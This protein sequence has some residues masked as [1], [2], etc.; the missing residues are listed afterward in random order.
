VALAAL[1]LGSKAFPV[2]EDVIREGLRTVFWPGRFEI[3]RENPTVLLDGAHNG[4]G[5]AALAE[6]LERYRQGRSIKLLF[7]SMED[8]DWRLMLTTLTRLADEVVLTRVAME[9]SAD[10]KLLA[11]HVPEAICH[12]VIEDARQ[13]LSFLLD[14]AA[15]D[16]LIVVAGSLY[17]LG[18]VRPALRKEADITSG[19]G[20]RATPTA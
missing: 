14:K 12:R 3:V 16:T 6:E 20:N 18:E 8:K 15:P 7:A 4:E 1:E 5:V 19:G 17:L 2:G 11:A 10:P 9:R 13:G